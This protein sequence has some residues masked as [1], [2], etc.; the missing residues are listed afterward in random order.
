MTL[1]EL[2]V[3]IMVMLSLIFILLVGAR[4][5]KKGADRSANI[6]NVRN[7]QQAVR[8]H[9]NTWEMDFGDPLAKT[10]IF[11]DYLREPSSPLGSP[12]QYTETVPDVGLLYITNPAV[13]GIDY[14]YT[15]LEVTFKIS[16][17]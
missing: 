1:L 14:W 13:D 8:G 7:V 15:E 3:V 2:T 6:M 11:D 9:Q 5:W 10:I 12:Y 16:T 4:A 17:W